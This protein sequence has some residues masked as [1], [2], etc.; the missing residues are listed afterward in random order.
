MIPGEGQSM[1]QK[2]LLI[3]DNPISRKM[4]RVTLETEGYN[5]LEA[6][7]GATGVALMAAEKPD[8]V[9]QDLLLP[10]I[11]GFDLVWQM[12]EQRPHE[13]VPILALTG[14]MG[15]ADAARVADAPFSD[16]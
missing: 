11:S 1:S 12:R 13:R 5:V 16:Y 3:E 6:P 8:L 15:K 2:I 4:V 10:D 7:D 9:L 14:L